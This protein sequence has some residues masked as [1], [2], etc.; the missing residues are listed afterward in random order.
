[1]GDVDYTFD[2]STHANTAASDHPPWNVK[3]SA[4]NISKIHVD[5]AAMKAA[6]GTVTYEDVLQLWDIPYPC[7][8]LSVWAK[9]TTA[10]G[11]T[12]GGLVGVGTNAASSFLGVLTLTTAATYVPAGSET[13]ALTGG[14]FFSSA[15]TLDAVFATGSV[16]DIGTAVFDVYVAWIYCSSF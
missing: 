11:E 14:K 12:C 7:W 5:M 13:Y 16:A 6:H 3:G 1:M 2:S 4:V 15:D 10:E 9:V 8:I